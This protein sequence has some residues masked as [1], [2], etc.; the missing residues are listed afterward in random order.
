MG[1][2]LANYIG[3]LLVLLIIAWRVSRNLRGRTINPSYLWIRPAI[4]AAILAFLL[5]ISLKPDA[6]ELSSL[7]GALVLGMGA[8]YLLSRHQA[9]SLQNGKIVSKT[10]PIGIILFMALLAARIF[11]RMQMESGQAP[12]QLAAHNA[13]IMFYTDVALTFLVALMAAQAWEIWRRARP[14]MAQKAAMG[15][16]TAPEP[17]AD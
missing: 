3:P 8:G 2:E 10:S 4:F 17:A 15:A 12:G 11:F 16:G 14:L 7:A 5:W 6:V 9:L 13:Q 1:K